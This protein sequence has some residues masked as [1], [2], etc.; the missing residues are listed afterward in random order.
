MGRSFDRCLETDD[1]I[2]DDKIIKEVQGWE[3][4]N[5]YKLG[6]YFCSGRCED[7]SG[8]RVCGNA[9]ECSR[10]IES[11]AALWKTNHGVQTVTATGGI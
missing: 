9:D 2:L 1:D 5:S 7:D 4:E 6:L 8:N 10:M 3:Q 11:A